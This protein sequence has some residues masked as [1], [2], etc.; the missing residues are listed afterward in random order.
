MKAEI[1]ADLSELERILKKIKSP[2]VSR[3]GILGGDAS[4][5][6]DESELTNSQ[7]GLIQEFGSETNNIPARSFL[8]MPLEEKQK[9][10]VE[11]LVTSEVKKSIENGDM[12]KVYKT[13]GIA[14]EQIV[15]EAFLSGGFG[16]WAPNAPITINGGWISNKVSGVPVY[17]EG[18]GTTKPLIDSGALMRSISSDVKKKS[19]V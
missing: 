16:K 10:L 5:V 12:E 15:K 18:K 1:S 13:L 17:I 11:T 9:E 14:G 3:V 6:H 8:R 19:E 4:E 7:I 2:Y